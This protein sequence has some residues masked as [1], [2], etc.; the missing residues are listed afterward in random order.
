MRVRSWL[1]TTLPR[2]QSCAVRSKCAQMS[3]LSTTAEGQGCVG[4][5]L[6]LGVPLLLFPGPEHGLNPLASEKIRTDS[7]IREIQALT[8]FI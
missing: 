7:R 8:P 4:Q 2:L 3:A 5:C 1:D 6:H